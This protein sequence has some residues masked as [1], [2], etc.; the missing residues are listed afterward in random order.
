MVDL[1]QHADAGE[2]D[3]L[4]GK[5][6]RGRLD[7]IRE[8]CQAYIAGRLSDQLSQCALAA[9]GEGRFRLELDPDDQDRQSLLFWYQIG[10]VYVKFVGTH[11]EYDKVDAATVEME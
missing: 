7:A 2:L 11:A 9:I 1:G 8:A 10:V 5:K 4:S 6:R 3:A